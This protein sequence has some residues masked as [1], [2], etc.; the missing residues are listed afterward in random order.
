MGSTTVNTELY[1]ATA[2]RH[3]TRGI[4]QGGVLSPLM[5]L[6]VVDKL[7]CQ[8]SGYIFCQCNNYTNASLFSSKE[9]EQ[10]NA[11]KSKVR[12]MRG[13]EANLVNYH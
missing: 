12:K 13:V 2:R 7:L 5:W 9:T 3:V 6:I 1:G 4:P 8:F 11:K 10:K